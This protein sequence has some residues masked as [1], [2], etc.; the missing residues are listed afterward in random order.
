MGWSLLHLEDRSRVGS[1]AW[2]YTLAAEE[3]RETGSL[4]WLQRMRADGDIALATADACWMVPLRWLQRM[5][6]VLGTL[7][8]LLRVSCEG[9]SGCEGVAKVVAD[10][11]RFG[12]V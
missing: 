3:V 1:V 10:V 2:L 11:R 7:R 4:R 5:Y 6:Y 8:G 12:R 9:G